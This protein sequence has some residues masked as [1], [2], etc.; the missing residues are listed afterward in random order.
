[1]QCKPHKRSELNTTLQILKVGSKLLRELEGP[2]KISGLPMS[3]FYN[4]LFKLIVLSAISAVASQ[5][6]G[7]N[8][9]LYKIGAGL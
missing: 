9:R 2:H 1:M 5:Y 4:S 8:L 3:P 7:L 6:L